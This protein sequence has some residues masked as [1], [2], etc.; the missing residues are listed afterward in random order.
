MRSSSP[1][2]GWWPN[3]PLWFLLLLVHAAFCF[4]PKR[5]SF[6]WVDT[7]WSVCAVLTHTSDSPG[8]DLVIDSSYLT[9]SWSF[10]P[11]RLHSL[12]ACWSCSVIFHSS[13][14]PFNNWNTFFDHVPSKFRLLTLPFTLSLFG[15]W[16]WMH[17]SCCKQ[18]PASLVILWLPMCRVISVWV[19]STVRHK[20]QSWF[21]SSSTLLV[22]G[23]KLW[24]GSD[25]A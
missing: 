3:S 4:C 1:I 15:D 22:T 13:P 18:F 8:S 12:V 9:Y 20:R 16:I 19:Y 21:S 25:F 23:G 2:S 10:D 17:T 6:G 14:G 24:T 11:I 7:H 5:L